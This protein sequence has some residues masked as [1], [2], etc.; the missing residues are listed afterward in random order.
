M[1]QKFAFAHDSVRC[2]TFD[3]PTMNAGIPAPPVSW[4]CYLVWVYHVMERV[5]VGDDGGTWL[6]L[7]V[8]CIPSTLVPLVGNQRHTSVYLLGWWDIESSHIT[9]ITKLRAY[10]QPLLQMHFF[11]EREVAFCPTFPFCIPMLLL[12]LCC[13]HPEPWRL[14]CTYHTPIKDDDDKEEEEDGWLIYARSF[15]MH[16]THILVFNTHKNP[17][18][19]SY[20]Y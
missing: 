18:K 9:K 5:G 13:C 16:F 4:D 14:S 3:S 17:V 2:R 7:E 6:G 8:T 20:G 10:G 1:W 19:R 12:C 15:S 11:F